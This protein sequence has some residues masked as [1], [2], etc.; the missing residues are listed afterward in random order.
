MN[1]RIYVSGRYYQILA[2]GYKRRTA[3][4]ESDARILSN[5]MIIDLVKKNGGRIYGRAR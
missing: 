4:A 2:L 1:E 5:Q 3:Q